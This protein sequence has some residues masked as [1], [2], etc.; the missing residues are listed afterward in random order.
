[1]KSDLQKKE[2][3]RKERVPYQDN[4]VELLYLVAHF[5]EKE[6][7]DFLKWTKELWK[8]RGKSNMCK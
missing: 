1:M 3:E 8:E 4:R 2:I 7:E 5:T 6:V